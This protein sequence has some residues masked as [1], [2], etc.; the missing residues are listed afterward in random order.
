MNLG[1]WLACLKLQSTRGA[2]IKS[3]ILQND[4]PQTS[5]VLEWFLA[6]SVN[7]EIA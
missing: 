2:D 7:C 4:C 1:D 6:V 3:M 5:S